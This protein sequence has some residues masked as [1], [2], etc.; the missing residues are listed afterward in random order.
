MSELSKDFYYS[1]LLKNKT[2]HNTQTKK[3]QQQQTHKN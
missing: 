3:T 1:S 2:K